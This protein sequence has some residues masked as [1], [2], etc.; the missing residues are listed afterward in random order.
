M[1]N[2]T[3]LF[4]A[5]ESATGDIKNVNTR[6]PTDA[7][8]GTEVGE[9]IANRY[10]LLERIGEGGMGTVWLA[11]QSHPV[12]H[13]VAIKLIKPGMDSHEVIA[14][15]DAE[16]QALAVMDH[17]NIAKV[18]DGGLTDKDRP[19]FVMEYVQGIPITKYCDQ[20]R[21][22]VGDRLQLFQSVCN[23]VQHA[24]QKGIIHRDLKPSNILV[25]S[26]DGKPAAKVIDFGL[27]KAT[28]QSLT[29]QTLV[30]AQGML[31]GTPL[32]MSPEQAESS[33]DIDTRT[34]I[35]SLGV[36]LYE[37]LTGGTPLERGQVKLAGIAELVRLIKEVEPPKPSSR[38]TRT[39]S[40]SN[41]ASQRNVDPSHLKRSL[42]GDLDWVVMKAL[43]KERNRRYATAKDLAADIQCH[44]EDK[45]VSAGP[46]SARY[47]MQK[48]VATKSCG[49]GCWPASRRGAGN[50]DYRNQLW[51]G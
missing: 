49:C 12:K 48:F 7:P 38:I 26:E 20:E 4:P 17:P 29:D 28:A 10:T 45:P 2:E 34:D 50:R 9:M 42:S 37:L 1:V 23:A 18:Y 14:R 27:A 36:V 32:Y 16:R 39:D 43:E 19:Y 22:S 30:T 21:L 33:V 13:R 40:A 8:A 3:S 25:C 35:Y 11:E 5:E 41:V 51:I 24:H 46:P 44:L 6:Q 15:F 47:W 31:L